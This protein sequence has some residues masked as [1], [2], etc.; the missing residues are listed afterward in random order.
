MTKAKSEDKESRAKQ[1]LQQVRSRMQN[2]SKELD[3]VKKERNNLTA[4]LNEAGSGN[5]CVL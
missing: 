3:A 1:L 5:C 2:L 4:Q